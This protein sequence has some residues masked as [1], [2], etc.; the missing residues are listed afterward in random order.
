MNEEDALVDQL[1]EMAK[2]PDR[3]SKPALGEM[4]VVAATEIIKL[5]QLNQAPMTSCFGVRSRTR[6]RAGDYPHSD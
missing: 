3:F 1:L 2:E 5:Q 6:Y 4:L